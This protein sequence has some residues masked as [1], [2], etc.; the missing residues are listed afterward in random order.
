MTTYWLSPPPRACDVCDD[1]ITDVFY[2]AKTTM[3]PWGCLCE[4]CFTQ[5][6]GL[7][8]LGTGLGQKYEKQ[9][10]GKWLKTGG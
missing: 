10:S 2:D 9:P 4:R 8:K 1:T 7:G 3:G 5:G 6:P